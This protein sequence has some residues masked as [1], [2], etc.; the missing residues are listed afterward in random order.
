MFTL[1]NWPIITFASMMMLAI[2]SKYCIA[3]VVTVCLLS[4]FEG[5]LMAQSII[6]VGVAVVGG[7]ACQPP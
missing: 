7:I 1:I 4:C 3:H 6:T 5:H 2:D